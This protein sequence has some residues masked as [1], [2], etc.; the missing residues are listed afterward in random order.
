MT[1]GNLKTPE[2]RCINRSAGDHALDCAQ[3]DRD[4]ERKCGSH[5]KPVNAQCN[6]QDTLL[7]L[8]TRQG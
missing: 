6:S 4:K 5:G 8:Q 1:G 2:Y 7:R 3:D